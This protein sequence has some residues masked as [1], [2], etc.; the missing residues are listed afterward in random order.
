ME[1]NFNALSISLL[2][3]GVIA[4]ITTTAIFFRSGHAVRTFAILMVGVSV[5]AL[6]YSMELAM[7]DLSH[8]LFWIKV[9]YIGIALI[10]AFWLVF[11]LQ[12]SGNDKY[13]NRQTIA[14]IFAIPV[15]TLL[16]VW[17]NEWHHLHYETYELYESDGLYLLNFEPAAWY[18]IHTIIFYCY[19]IFGTLL[20]IQKY[21]SV[22]SLYKKQI[23]VVLLGTFIPWITNALY[24]MDFKP[25]E[26]LDLTPFMFVFTGMII[27]FGLLRFKLF[28]ILPF[29][30][31]KIIEEMKEGI[32][33]LDE[34]YHV[35]DSNPPFCKLFNSTDSELI[36]KPIFTL[37]KHDDLFIK[38]LELKEYVRFDYELKNNGELRQYEV[39]IN[40]IQND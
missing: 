30:R 4:V 25:L 22:K 18:I 7:T 28:E 32:L 20:L 1:I 39:T 36:G 21:L 9:E 34:I 10:P 12:F 11:V 17:T 24:L 3:A 38:K 16:F 14:L 37:F 31:E 40:P 29:A 27:S 23:R 33:I 2:I 26:H 5:W 13:L 6:A 8:I 19:L 15:L 35:I